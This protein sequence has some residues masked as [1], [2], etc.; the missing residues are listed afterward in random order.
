MSGV[1]GRL[2]QHQCAIV[3]AT[4]KEDAMPNATSYTR[5]P[6]RDDTRASRRCVLVAV[7]AEAGLSALKAGRMMAVRESRPFVVLSIVEPPPLYAFDP[8]QVM[9]VPWTIDEQLAARRQ[10]VQ[11]RLAKLGA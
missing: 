3:V 2:D 1:R 4:R 8:E 10:S 7:G 5:E 9:A 6:S 11:E